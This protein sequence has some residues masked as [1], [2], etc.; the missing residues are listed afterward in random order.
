MAYVQGGELIAGRWSEAKQLHAARRAVEEEGEDERVQDAWILLGRKQ[1][2]HEHERPLVFHQQARYL[3]FVID[4]HARPVGGGSEV[5]FNV[6][7]LQVR[8]QFRQRLMRVPKYG[9]CAKHSPD[10]CFGIE[11][12]LAS[13]SHDRA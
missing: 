10:V 13:Y 6:S 9:V 3:D 4:E 7:R 5:R 2:T 12:H 1:R 11:C 8:V